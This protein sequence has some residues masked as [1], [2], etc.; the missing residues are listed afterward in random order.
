MADKHPRIPVKTSHRPGSA[1]LPHLFPNGPC[2]YRTIDTQ[3]VI[4]FYHDGY[5]R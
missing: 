4:V 1:P 3:E 2:F 5:D